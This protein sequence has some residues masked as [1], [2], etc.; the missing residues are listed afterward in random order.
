MRRSDAVVVRVQREV[1]NRTRA[2]VMTGWLSTLVVAALACIDGP[3]P[4]PPSVTD[5]STIESDAAT[6]RNQGDTDAPPATDAGPTC[7]LAGDAGVYRGRFGDW[8][9]PSSVPKGQCIAG[10][11]IEFN[12]NPCCDEPDTPELKR[13]KCSC[14]DGT[15]SC[16]I[17]SQGAGYC[18]DGSSGS[19]LGDPT[20]TP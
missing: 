1:V 12:V 19:Y 2:I 3:R 16:P 4:F 7:G 14:V 8:Y 20:C 10:C 18:G 15:W 13:Y 11:S 9:P 17:V 5:A 6:D